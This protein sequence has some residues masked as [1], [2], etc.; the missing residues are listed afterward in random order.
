MHI[1]L[2][3]LISRR[4][5]FSYDIPKNAELSVIY[6]KHTGNGEAGQH[7]FL[8]ESLI[9]ISSWALLLQMFVAMNRWANGNSQKAFPGVTLLAFVASARDIS[10]TP[11]DLVPKFFEGLPF[12]ISTVPSETNLAHFFFPDL[13]LNLISAESC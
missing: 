1:C 4:K 8:S 12:N 10:V 3:Y 13:N 5:H 7:V 6:D 11:L 2:Q 9:Q